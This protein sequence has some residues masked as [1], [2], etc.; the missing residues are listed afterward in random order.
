MVPLTVCLWARGVQPLGKSWRWL[1]SAA[2]AVM[3]LM[4]RRLAELGHQR[5]P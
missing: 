5:T 4:R 1:F 3:S 2:P